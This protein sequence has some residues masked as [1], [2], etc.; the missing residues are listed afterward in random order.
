MIVPTG[1]AVPDLADGAAGLGS[2]ATTFDDAVADAAAAPA[3]AAVPATTAVLLRI[4]RRATRRVRTPAD[5]CR[6][7]LADA[8]RAFLPGGLVRSRR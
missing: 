5:R 4:V 1:T 8:R 3:V 2:V 6:I 7:G